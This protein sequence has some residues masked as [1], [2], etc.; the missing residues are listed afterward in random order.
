MKY[1]KLG[2]KPDTFYTEDGTSLTIMQVPV[3]RCASDL[4]VQVNDTRYRLHKFPLLLKCGLL[5]SLCADSA[6]AALADPPGGEEGFELC[7]KFAYGIAINLSAHN[8]V[9]A[10]CSA[11]FLKMTEAVARGNLVMK[12]EA[13]FDS[14]VLRG[15]KDC[16]VTLNT[17]RKFAVWSESLG[18]VHR[19]IESLVHKILT[20]PPRSSPRE[21][22]RRERER[23]VS[24]SYTYT[25]PGFSGRESRTVPRDWWTEDISELDF[26]HFRTII[27]AI[28]LHVYACKHLLLPDPAATSSS[29]E[30]PSLAGRR[31]LLESLVGMIPADHGSVSGRFLLRLLRAAALLGASSSTTAEL[32]A[33][34][35]LLFPSP[36]DPKS[37]NLDLVEL[38]LENFLRQLRYSDGGSAATASV[39]KVVKTIDAYLRIVA[40]SA[41]TPA[42]KFTALA[43]ALPEISRP[44]HDDLYWAVDTFL[45][46]HAEL[47]KEEK[48]KLCRLI[49][50]RNLSADARSHAVTNDRL[51]LRTIVQVLFAEQEKAAAAAAAA[52]GV[53]M[54]ARAPPPPR[55]A[56]RKAEASGRGRRRSGEDQ[57]AGDGLISHDRPCY[58]SDLLTS[59]LPAIVPPVA[60]S[61][62]QFEKEFNE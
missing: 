61:N 8:L 3:I 41:G 60:G 23:A 57:E 51:P 13:F 55:T 58:L 25:R 2:S 59:A 38:L 47:S 29:E 48:K 11:R 31:R 9:A 40:A 27:S 15:W 7:V 37:Y 30:S 46:E 53:A 10:V 22:Q 36:S 5:Q 50:C 32:A 24:W 16:I 14:C 19:C 18:I 49:D 42:A 21:R 62:Y 4:L 52:P 45:K 6:E 17:A 1:M 43:D 33:P 44:E 28:P 26:E 34:P 35:D 56:T 39:K 54:A 20:H 12:L